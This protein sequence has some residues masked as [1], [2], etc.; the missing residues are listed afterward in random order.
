M[1]AR[2]IPA[3]QPRPDDA[4]SVPDAE[5]GDRGAEPAVATIDAGRIARRRREVAARLYT[6]HRL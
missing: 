1:A 5:A 3:Q 6:F 4:R 2:P